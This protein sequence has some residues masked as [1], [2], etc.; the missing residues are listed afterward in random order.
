MTGSFQRRLECEF[1]ARR[2]ANPRYSL[3]AFAVSLAA[4]HSTLSQVLRGVRPVPASS[5][6]RW[7]RRLGLS[8]E[9]VAAYIAAQH[10]RDEGERSRET[11]LA[12]WSAEALAI[13]E[14]PEH[15]HVYQAAASGSFEGD[16]R[17]L[18]ERAG[19]PIDAVNIAL[20]R[21]LR[22]GLVVTA[23]D[24]RW[25]ATGTPAA[26]PAEFRTLAL[27]RIRERQWRTP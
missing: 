6:R 16:S 27:A 20:A 8:E 5:I 3:R 12:H 13:I 1:E 25:R 23:S 11:E 26:H 24:G 19:V 17:S 15:W 10:L 2:A 21:L 18:A 22:L 9:E 7:G 14:Q 4:D